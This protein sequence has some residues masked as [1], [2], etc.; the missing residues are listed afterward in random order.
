MKLCARFAPTVL[1]PPVTLLSRLQFSC[2]SGEVAADNADDIPTEEN[3]ERLEEMVETSQS[4]ARDHLKLIIT[5]TVLAINSCSQTGDLTDDK[6]LWLRRMLHRLQQILFEVHCSWSG[7]GARVALAIAC[8][9]RS[10]SLSP[11][12]SLTRDLLPLQ[13][14]ELVLQNLQT[15]EPLFVVGHE[16][17]VQALTQ[18]TL[19]Q[20]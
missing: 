14:H 16:S 1:F 12:R 15:F 2:D 10:L 6:N 11:V 19:L 20:A 5:K 4:E 17:V 13:Y 9:T 7:A 18:L 3:I 8:Q